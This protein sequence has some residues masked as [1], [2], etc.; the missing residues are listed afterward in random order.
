MTDP[1]EADRERA[2]EIINSIT[3][4]LGLKLDC[5]EILAK[6]LATTRS[7]ARRMAIE[8]CE[9]LMASY[10]SGNHDDRNR[11]SAIRALDRVRAE[12]K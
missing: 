2:R 3:S 1:T 5:F 7:E 12:K 8:E 11:A 9:K 4:S 6:S 10:A